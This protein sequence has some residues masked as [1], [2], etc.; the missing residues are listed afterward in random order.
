M[1]TEINIIGPVQL[2]NYSKKSFYL[3]SIVI[4]ENL[5]FITLQLVN[6]YL[7]VFFY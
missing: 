2:L 4:E 5:F 6:V 7:L 3:L 1:Y